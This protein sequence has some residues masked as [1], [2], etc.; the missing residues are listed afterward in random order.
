MHWQLI[1]P[2]LCILQAQRSATLWNYQNQNPSRKTKNIG[3]IILSDNCRHL[4]PVGPLNLQNAAKTSA[5][6]EKSVDKVT[7]ICERKDN[8]NSAVCQYGTVLPAVAYLHWAEPS[9]HNSLHSR[10]AVMQ[11]DLSEQCSNCQIK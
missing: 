6:S 9:A 7:S 11:N 8:I 5:R 2:S 10:I 1:F 4:L 3:G